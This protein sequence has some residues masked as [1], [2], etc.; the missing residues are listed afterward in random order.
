[1]V[2]R[3]W[4]PVRGEISHQREVSKLVKGQNFRRKGFIFSF[5]ES[6]VHDEERGMEIDVFGNV[7]RGR[8]VRFKG[9]ITYCLGFACQL[10][11]P[12]KNNLRVTGHPSKYSL[13]C[14]VI[15]KSSSCVSFCLTK[16]Q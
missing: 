11:R 8:D 9:P 1:M 12:S 13:L 3:R 10:P 15:E 4:C 16:E 14:R 2:A 5:G 7:A 6:H